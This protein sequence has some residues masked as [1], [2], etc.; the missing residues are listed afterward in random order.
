MTTNPPPSRPPHSEV[1]RPLSRR[2]ALAH[3]VALAATL[4]LPQLSAASP[5]VQD[6]TQDATQDPGNFRAIYGDEVLRARF[7]L[8][9][10]HVY[11][12]YPEGPFHQLITTLTREHTSDQAIY[13]GLLNALPEIQPFLGGLR[14]ALPS[15]SE[16]REVI[17]EQT[18]SL[19]EGRTHFERYLSIGTTGR[20]YGALSDALSFE[21]DPLFVSYQAPTYGLTD[22]ID[23]GQVRK[24]GDFFDLNDYTPLT[25]NIER[26]SVDLLTV[27]IGF[28]HAPLERRERFIASCVEVLKPGGFLIVRDHDAFSPEYQHLVALAHDVFNAGLGVSWADNHAEVRHFTTLANLSARLEGHGLKAYGELLLQPGDP[29][30]NTLMR[31][32]RV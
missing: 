18:L 17:S 28:H 20:Y 6:A 5:T 23:R 3:C 2:E 13:E 1:T 10:T 26:E 27:Y 29:T 25:A 30:I 19:L 9:L 15:L 16:Q 8:F 22:I 24:R 4:C 11:H 7:K 12:L 21:R 32:D 14:Y 31:F